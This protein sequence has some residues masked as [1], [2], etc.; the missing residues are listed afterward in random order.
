MLDHVDFAVVNH[1]VSRAF[2]VA[3]LEPLGLFPICEIDRADGRKGTGFGAG[4][5]GEFWVGGGTP[6]QGRLH[7][8]FAAE[9]ERAVDAFF[10]AAI[11]A[12]G[13]NHGAP[14]L[15]KE[16]GENYYAAFVRDPDGH[17][18]E[19][20]FRGSQRLARG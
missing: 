3:A 5:I 4:A 17:V 12:G 18:I 20:V 15:R 1:A 9:S 6:V 19:A 14:G 13:T 2:Y 16:Y 11:R 8:A 10:A 7:V